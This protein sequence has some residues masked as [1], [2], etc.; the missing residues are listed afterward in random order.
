LNVTC[1][2]LNNARRRMMNKL[3]V[4][5]WILTLRAQSRGEDVNSVEVRERILR[6]AEWVLNQSGWYDRI[7][8][9]PPDDPLRAAEEL[10]RWVATD[11]KPL[12][13]VSG[14][15]F[16]GKGTVLKAFHAH[17][18]NADI[19]KIVLATTRAPRP[20]E[21]DGVDYHF[22]NLAQLERLAAEGSHLV[23]NVYKHG[24]GGDGTWIGLGLRELSNAICHAVQDKTVRYV[25]ETTPE[26]ASEIAKL[27]AGLCLTVFVTCIPTDAHLLRDMYVVD[28][29][30]H[31]IGLASSAQRALLYGTAEWCH[32]AGPKLNLDEI[33]R[34][35]TAHEGLH[36]DGHRVGMGD[37]LAIANGGV[38]LVHTSP[39]GASFEPVPHDSAWISDHIVWGY[40]KNPQRHITSH[41]L[42]TAFSDRDRA[43]RHVRLISSSA[44][45]AAAAV[46]DS[47]IHALAA[48]INRYVADF[49]QWLGGRLIH[50]SVIAVSARLRARLGNS[51]LAAKPLGA[52]SAESVCVVLANRQAT[53]DAVKALHECGWEACP[54]R[55]AGGLECHVDGSKWIASAPYRLDLVAAADLG[56]D[57]A[58]SCHGACCAIA[59]EPRSSVTIERDIE[60]AGRA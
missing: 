57:P 1:D 21:R 50:E 49:D 46:A 30:L 27:Y 47:D 17:N 31:S 40:R 43:R 2:K 44:F 12:T 38:G 45:S 18:G 41:V 22:L 37:V 52:G 14:P 7:L 55:V 59:I 54:V 26:M 34:A 56:A 36:A 33:V 15:A 5:Q 25:L 23:H 35:A 60:P 16:A 28:G 24:N 51:L 29:R 32:R 13:V 20:G 39:S 53:E 3:E 10:S 19:R 6:G 48:A 4:I 9:N 58:I 42:A 11:P 8:Y